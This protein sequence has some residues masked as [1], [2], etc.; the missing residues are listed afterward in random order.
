LA[1]EENSE[2]MREPFVTSSDYVEGDGDLEMGDDERKVESRST[3]TSPQ[4]CSV[5]RYTPVWSS[6]SSGA[7][8]GRGYTQKAKLPDWALKEY[9]KD[10]KVGRESLP[11]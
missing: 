3:N 8:S 6:S 11:E 4:V 2:E 10:S 5:R 9:M 7:Y 1:K